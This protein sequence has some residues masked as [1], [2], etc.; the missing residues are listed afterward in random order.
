MMESLAALLGSN[1]A[2]TTV[3]LAIIAL[4]ASFLPLNALTYQRFRSCRKRAKVERIMKLLKIGPEDRARFLEIKPGPFLCIAVIYASAVAILGLTILLFGER[5]S[6]GVGSL[7]GPDT[8]LMFGMGFLGGY[9]WGIQYV[10]RRYTVDD[11]NPGV[12]HALAVRMVLAGVLAAVI[13]NAYEATV[14]GEAG[15]VSDKIWPALALVL[16]MFPQRGITWIRDRVPFLSDDEAPGMRKAPLEMIEGITFHDRV[17]LEEEGI[18][19]CYDLATADFVPL[20][21]NTPYSARALTEWMLQ[22]KL[23]I[24]APEAMPNLRQQ[25]IRSIL[26]LGSLD[27]DGLKALAEATSVTKSALERAQ[28]SLTADVGID[29]LRYIGNALS[30]FSGIEDPLGLHLVVGGKLKATGGCDVA[31]CA[32]L[33]VVGI[34]PHQGAAQEAWQDVARRA[35]GDTSIRYFI[36]RVHRLD[37]PAAPSPDSSPDIRPATPGDGKNASRRPNGTGADRGTVVAGRAA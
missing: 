12:Y 32:E 24:F 9:L 23:C 27:G 28:R 35:A 18:D 10:L 3:Q 36:G 25:G 33:K 30:K 16:G 7:A 14:G 37:H 6:L 29:R 1:P 17:R 8:W 21:I 13:F 11:L 20:V 22:A 15:A 31:D 2:S 5:M 19:N 26:D 4:L 34:Y